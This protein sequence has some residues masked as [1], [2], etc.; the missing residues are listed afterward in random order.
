[1]YTGKITNNENFKMI[2]D[3]TSQSKTLKEKYPLLVD[4]DLK[5][6]KGKENDLL[7]RVGTRLNKKRDE[8]INILRK[9]QPS[10]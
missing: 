5:F 1:M 9:V 4:A 8:V 3:W 10:A 2:G 7:T 6:E